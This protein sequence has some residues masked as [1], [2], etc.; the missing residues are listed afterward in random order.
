M[1]VKTGGYAVFERCIQEEM[2]VDK[3][4]WVEEVESEMMSSPAA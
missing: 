2:V 4:R 1:W 3:G